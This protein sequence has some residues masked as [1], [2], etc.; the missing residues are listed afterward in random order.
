MKQAIVIFMIVAWSLN[1]YT[2]N[3]YEYING[4]LYTGDRVAIAYDHYKKKFE[5]VI[6]ICPGFFNSKENRWMRKAVDLVLSQHDAIVFD[7]RGHG[8]SGGEY[9]WSA[10]EHLDINAVLDYAQL[11]GYRR[12]GILAFSLGAASSINA[13]AQREDVDSMIL[14]SAPTSFKNVNFCFWEPGMMADLIDN[15]ECKWEGKGAR[16]ASIF[17]PKSKPL[18]T[19][20]SIRHTPMFFIHGTRD[21][22]IKDYHSKRL[23]AA[24]PTYKKIEIIKDG[25]H[26]ERLIQFY[27]DK[28]KKLIL[29][30]FLETFNRADAE[31]EPYHKW[32]LENKPDG[33]GL[34]RES[35]RRILKPQ[36]IKKRNFWP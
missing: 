12:I 18:I 23:Y 21:W 1:A 20:A 29:D 34:T 30:W 17:T 5:S 8:E 15:I 19:I 2:E 11:Q 7:F 14:V 10:K 36:R 22:V 3:S 35:I 26:A 4:M 31:E 16:V 27:P 6:V 25:F 9:T 33:Y 13:V 32:Y 24:A 28:L